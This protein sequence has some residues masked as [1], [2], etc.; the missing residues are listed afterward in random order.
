[1]RQQ[2]NE[3]AA[4]AVSFSSIFVTMPIQVYL[5]F[6]IM[7]MGLASARNERVEFGMIF[8]RGPNVLAKV[9]SMVAF[10]L[11]IGFSMLACCAGF[12][13]LLFYW[14]FSFVMI[15]KNVGFGESFSLAREVT[16]GNEGST[17]VMV[18]MVIGISLL[19]ILALCI[20]V[21]FTNPLCMMIWVTAYLMMSGQVKA[22]RAY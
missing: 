13:V 2:G 17:V 6:G 5:S 15:D 9:G 10:Y 1:L 20:G 12:I 7:T 11:L 8:Y 16:R 22:G 4:I 19:G 14:P 21:I 18:L 3:Q